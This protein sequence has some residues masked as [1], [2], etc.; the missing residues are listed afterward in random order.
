MSEKDKNKNHLLMTCMYI[1]VSTT[2]FP[3][4][5]YICYVSVIFGGTPIKVRKTWVWKDKKILNFQ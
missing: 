3:D 4:E 2:L 5:K 1:P